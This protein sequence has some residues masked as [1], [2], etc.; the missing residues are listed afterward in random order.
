[1]IN[2][3]HYGRRDRIG[4]FTSASG[5]SL[6]YG[7]CRLSVAIDGNSG[8]QTRLDRRVLQAWSAHLRS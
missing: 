4:P 7:C 6:T 2:R 3:I 1:M 5:P 8:H